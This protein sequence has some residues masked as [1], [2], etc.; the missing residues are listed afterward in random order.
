MPE[1]PDIP[2]GREGSD[3]ECSVP[4]LGD[5]RL[6]LEHESRDH[7]PYDRDVMHETPHSLAANFLFVAGKHWKVLVLLTSS[8][9]HDE[10]AEPSV[11]AALE[12]E[13]SPPQSQVFCW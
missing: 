9:A 10:P 3:L 1:R 13:L 12:R 6:R 2:D 7:W 8:S 11:G 4:E 5:G